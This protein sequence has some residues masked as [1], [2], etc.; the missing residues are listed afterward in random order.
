MGEIAFQIYLLKA[1]ISTSNELGMKKWK[2]RLV[3]M[4]ICP[5]LKT[6]N[7]SCKNKK[8]ENIVVM[9]EQLNS[10]FA[11]SYASSISYRIFTNIR[12]L[13]IL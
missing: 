11:N 1:K 4:K 9:L 13:V 3:G 8:K 5:F 10:S 12:P 2:E 7:I 6:K